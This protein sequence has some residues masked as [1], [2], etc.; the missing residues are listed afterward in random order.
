MNTEAVITK[1][2][3][4]YGDQMLRLCAMYLRDTALAEDAA[5]ETFLRAYRA[6]DRFR[7]DS[8]PKTWLTRIAINVCKD[9][10]HKRSRQPL[11]LEKLPEISSESPAYDDSVIS[12][13]MQLPPK[14]RAVILLRYYQELDV[15]DIAK[16]LGITRSSASVRLNRAREML[17][18]R[19]ETWYFDR[20]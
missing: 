20:P 10:S 2:M 1:L 12:E 14:Y 5:Q 9:M 17:R 19:I 7:G 11:S 13:V 16:V 3:N 6:L 18:L 8:S 4:E 15:K